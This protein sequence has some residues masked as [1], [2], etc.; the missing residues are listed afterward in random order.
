METNFTSVEIKLESGL[1]IEAEE[2]CPMC[3]SNISEIWSKRI[4]IQKFYTYA[5]DPDTFI[6]VVI[7]LHNIKCVGCGLTHTY[8]EEG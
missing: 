7:W 4:I 5:D 1:V 6:P 2:T 8:Q 3:Q